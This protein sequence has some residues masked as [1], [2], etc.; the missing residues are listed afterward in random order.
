MHSATY[1]YKGET[2]DELP[3]SVNITCPARPHP[4]TRA[5][6]N[7]PGRGGHRLSCFLSSPPSTPSELSQTP[8]TPRTHFLTLHT[9]SPIES[10]A[11][12]QL[13]ICSSKHPGSSSPEFDRNCPVAQPRSNSYPTQHGVVASGSVRMRFLAHPHSFVSLIHPSRIVLVV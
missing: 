11:F 9:F 13:A 5:T 3:F 8:R 12:P 2:F 6:I 7:G 4:P 10:G 1:M